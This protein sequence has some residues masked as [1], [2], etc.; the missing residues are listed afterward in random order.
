MTSDPSSPPMSLAPRSPNLIT[1]PRSKPSIVYRGA[2]GRRRQDRSRNI[3]QQPYWDGSTCNLASRRK[4][5]RI[6]SRRAA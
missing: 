4:R 3:E 2:A 6:V 1:A 5:S